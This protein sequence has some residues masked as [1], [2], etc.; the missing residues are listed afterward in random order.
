MKADSDGVV[1]QKLDSIASK[2]R[3]LLAVMGGASHSQ[4]ATYLEASKSTV[5]QMLRGVIKKG[6]HANE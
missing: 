5:V 6:A 4:I 3:H 1:R 2:A